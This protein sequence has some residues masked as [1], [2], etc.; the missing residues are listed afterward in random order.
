MVLVSFEKE[1]CLGTRPLASLSLWWKGKGKMP[2][3]LAIVKSEEL[4]YPPQDFP[5]SAWYHFSLQ[6]HRVAAWIELSPIPT[7]HSY[8]EAITPSPSQCDIIWT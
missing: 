5:L 2:V 7:L 4:K 6:Q 3:A 1:H 8:V